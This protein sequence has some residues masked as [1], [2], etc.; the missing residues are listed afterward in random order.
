MPSDY[1]EVFGVAPDA[2]LETIKQ[3]YRVLVREHHPDVST[4]EDAHVR[5]QQI[6][7][8]WSVLS[9]PES[10]KRYDLSRREATQRSGD[11]TASE[12]A[13]RARPSRSGGTHKAKATSRPKVEVNPRASNPR[14]RLLVMVNEAAQLYQQEG[15]LDAAI[16]LCS[17]VLKSDPKNAEA[18]GLLGDIYVK[19]GRHDIALLMYKRA[20]QSQPNM[21][22]YRQKWESL[23]QKVSPES[24]PAAPA[25]GGVTTPVTPPPPPVK[26]AS[27]SP[28]VALTP[29]AAASSQGTGCGTSILLGLGAVSVGLAWLLTV[30]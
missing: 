10:R 8:A 16:S 30:L 3:R 18:A 4:S 6:L 26:P 28:P 25:S 13:P 2:D 11:T 24:T 14:T 21:L 23:Q 15:N 20:M 5:M 17:R 9:Q 12:N 1:Y 29:K 22:L 27:P 19:Q 7:E